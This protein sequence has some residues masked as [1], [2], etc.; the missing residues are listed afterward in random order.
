[1]N[2]LTRIFC[3]KLLQ[4]LIYVNP[5]IELENSLLKKYQYNLENSKELN[6]CIKE[7]IL[8]N[9]PGEIID[10]IFPAKIRKIDSTFAFN[11]NLFGNGTN[12]TILKNKLNIT[13]GEYE[14]FYQQLFKN[15]QTNQKYK[16]DVYMYNPKAEIYVNSSVLEPLSYSYQTSSAYAINTFCQYTKKINYLSNDAFEV[17]GQIFKLYHNKLIIKGFC[18][19]DCLKSLVSIYNNYY[20]NKQAKDVFLI[21]L[22]WDFVG[23]EILDKKLSEKHQ[24]IC[25]NYIQT[26]NQFMEF[27]NQICKLFAKI[28]INLRIFN[29]NHHQMIQLLGKN[30]N[31]Y[32]R[33]YKVKV[34]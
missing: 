15:K 20:Q 2:K 1:M 9:N 11:V 33:R 8:Q 23:V 30:P 25:Q 16:F 18:S 3:Q 27:E 4:R 17:F 6:H 26:Q 10:K 13:E 34:I 31:G 22:N 24:I 21:N 14:I 19:I 29:L 7:N 28:G 32:L 5:K 12:A